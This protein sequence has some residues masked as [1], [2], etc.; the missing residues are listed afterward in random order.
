MYSFLINKMILSTKFVNNIIILR[1]E[2]WKI[3]SWILLVRALCVLHN[4]DR[5][6]YRFCVSAGRGLSRSM[7]VPRLARWVTTQPRCGGSRRKSADHRVGH[8][9]LA[10]ASRFARTILT[11][12]RLRDHAAPRPRNQALV[13]PIGPDARLQ[14]SPAQNNGAMDSSRARSFC[15][16][17]GDHLQPGTGL[18]HVRSTGSC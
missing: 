5:C 14:G 15:G 4:I 1:F 8:A 12:S 2:F 17:S 11:T 10:T 3:I 7:F 16:R 9:A 13:V 18:L 6:L